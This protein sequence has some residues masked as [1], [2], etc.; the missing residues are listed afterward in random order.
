M[1]KIAV[2]A[3]GSDKGSSIVVEAVK[4]FLNDYKDV[5]LTVYGKKEELLEFERK[6]SMKNYPEQQK[7]NEEISKL[8]K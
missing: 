3:M 1:I 4:N 8:Y 6:L 7:Y 5:E 2:D